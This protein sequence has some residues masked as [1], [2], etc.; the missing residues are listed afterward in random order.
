MVAALDAAHPAP[1][2]VTEWS[3]YMAAG[4]T[5][6]GRRVEMVEGSLI[7]SPAPAPFHQLAG[8]RLRTVL[9]ASA[10]SGLLAM[11]AV[12]VRLPN[13]GVI[14]DIVVVDEAAV[15]SDSALLDGAN[16]HLVVEI[17][18]PS[19]R[20]TDRRVKPELYASAGIT[21][22]WRLELRPFRGQLPHE[23]LPVLFAYSVD[24]SGGYE[25]LHRVDA[26]SPATL[27]LPFPVKVDLSALLP[28]VASDRD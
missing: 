12:G 7:V 26:S 18:S 3:A 13:A 9:D 15:A 14:P 24:A 28:R 22:F 27:S 20:M 21:N 17:V 8:D 1:W 16:V 19:T 23:R 11:T 10:P 2:T 6:D 25:L 4:G 5:G